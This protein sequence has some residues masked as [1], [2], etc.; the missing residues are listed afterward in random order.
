MEFYGL[1]EL[2]LDAAAGNN[3]RVCVRSALFADEG[4]SASAEL[5][6]AALFD[7]LQAGNEHFFDP[8]ELGA[9]KLAHVIEARVNL[10]ELGIDVSHNKAEQR[11]VE[12]HRNA[13]QDVE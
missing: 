1:H 13:N 8:A 11:G 4:D 7:V 9:P 5:V 3:D 12:Q 6:S 2:C 10:A